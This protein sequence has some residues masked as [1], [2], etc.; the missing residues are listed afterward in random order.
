MSVNCR[1]A[2]IENTMTLQ[3][4]NIQQVNNCELMQQEKLYLYFA[5]IT[6]KF[7][8]GLTNPSHNIAMVESLFWSTVL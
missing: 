2:K 8:V 7:K 5:N 4:P 3:F 6:S 1:H